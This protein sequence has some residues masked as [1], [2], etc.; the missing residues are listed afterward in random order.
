MIS[1]E[2]GFQK[3]DSFSNT[4]LKNG[5]RKDYIG[6]GILNQVIKMG[7]HHWIRSPNLKSIFLQREGIESRF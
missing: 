4:V 6:F 3:R 7:I 1:D 5:I 2:S